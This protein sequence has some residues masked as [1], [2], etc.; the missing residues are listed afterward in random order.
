MKYRVLLHFLRFLVY[1]KRFFWW[2]GARFSFVFGRFFFKIAGLLALLK[3]KIQ[4]FFKK[5]GLPHQWL[6]KRGFLQAAIFAVL[7]VLSIP[8]SK[9]LANHNLAFTGQKTPAYV[10]LGADQDM[11]IEQVTSDAVVYRQD[12]PSWKS[13]TLDS[14][15]MGTSATVQPMTTELSAIVAGGTTLS[16]PM[17]LPGTTLNDVRLSEENYIV[18]A[19]DSI[20]VIAE[21]FGVSVA[22]IL[23]ENNL[24]SRSYIK[25]G[26]VLR[27]PPVTGVMHSV[28]KGDTLKKIALTYGADAEK[29]IAFNHLKE[30]GSNLTVG[31]R[32]MIPDGER[33]ASVSVPRVQPK[34]PVVSRVATP[35][36]SQ[37]SPSASGFVWPSGARTITQYYGIRH[38]AL[39]IAGPWQTATYAAKAGTV[40]KS[41][42]GWNS[43]YGCQIII[44]HGGGLKTLYAHHSKLLVSV[45]DYVET[46]QTI[47]LMGNSGNVRG[48][49]G[50]HLH[51]EVIRNG[52]RV[53]PL[54]YVR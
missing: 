19:G 20:S 44:D 23:W 21:S 32:L 54:Q 9:L 4:S 34:S 18:E 51:F 45:G 26:D 50:I 29:I 43:G 16:K 24:T 14:R 7:G 49:T 8:E 47:G 46:G 1:S 53:N 3:Y 12:V 11:E 48:V 52:V 25:P 42:C 22:T 37:S 38:H 41:Q 40:E 6:V 27:I 39:D 2:L 10:L 17:I 13:A 36:S 5:V 15:F 30:D 33:Q 35:P 28:K 31:D